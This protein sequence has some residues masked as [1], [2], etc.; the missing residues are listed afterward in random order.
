MDNKPV[1]TQKGRFRL[2]YK[3]TE[4]LNCG[5]P[6]DISDKFCPNCSQA[7]STKKLSLKDFFDE[8]FSSLISYDSKLLKTLSA[9][10]LRPGKITQDYID[11]KRVSYTNPFRFLLSLAIIYF[12]IL[13]VSGNI[14]E[15]NV[16][17]SRANIDDFDLRTTLDTLYFENEQEKQEVMA[18]LDSLNLSKI[19]SNQIGRRDS[20]M[21]VDATVYFAL[22]NERSFWDRYYHKQEFFQAWSIKIRSIVLLKRNK[23]SAFPKRPRTNLHLIQVAAFSEQRIGRTNSCRPLFRDF[24]LRPFS[25]FQFLPSSFGWPTS[26]KNTHIPII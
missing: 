1:I 19:M 4:C 11:G 18:T 6:L 2:K 14:A 24:L 10:L 25:F 13:G 17:K 7:N 15:I 3:G 21:T 9:L 26:E 12:L 16:N 5:H 22:L 20:A 23:N 8:F